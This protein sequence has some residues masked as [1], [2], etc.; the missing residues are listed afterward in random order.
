MLTNLSPFSLCF[1]SLSR[2]KTLLS[3]FYSSERVRRAWA[4]ACVCVC[5]PVCT[6]QCQRFGN[7]K[8]LAASL[9]LFP[10]GICTSSQWNR[11][12]CI[13]TLHLW[14]CF[15]FNSSIIIVSPPVNNVGK[16]IYINILKL[17]FMKKIIF[18]CF[19]E[20]KVIV[21]TTL[22]GNSLENNYKIYFDF[23]GKL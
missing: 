5:A 16:K 4:C 9:L 6:G 3:S 1:S 20:Y 10:N 19:R 23:Q 8:S 2:R 18:P 21:E 7:A 13:L 14:Y 15:Q 12:I 22:W 11:L 17:S